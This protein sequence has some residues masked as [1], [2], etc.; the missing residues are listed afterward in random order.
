MAKRVKKTKTLVALSLIL[1]L[2]VAWGQVKEPQQGAGAADKP[3]LPRCPVMDEPVDFFVSTPTDDGPVYFCCKPC[4]TKYNKNPSEYSQ[5]VAAQR[6]ALAKLP[7]VQVACPISNKP[8]RSDVS[9]DDKGQKIHFCCPKCIE[10]FKADPAKQQARMAASYT[11]QTACP[12]DGAPIDPSVFIKVKGENR[13]FFH[14]LACKEAFLKDPKPF[15]PKL[16]EQGIALEAS[17]IH[18]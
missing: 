17:D 2:S 12:V 14:Q 10:E 18:E 3:P 1:G 7:K 8:V 13:I 4:I 5:K 6:T 11:Y 15:L 16:E 9:L